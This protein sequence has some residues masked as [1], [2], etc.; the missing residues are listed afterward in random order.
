MKESKSYKQKLKDR[1]KS[2][3]I[4]KEAATKEQKESTKDERAKLRVERSGHQNT[5]VKLGW[6]TDLNKM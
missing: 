6:K 2:P 5:R 3:D 4:S 1:N